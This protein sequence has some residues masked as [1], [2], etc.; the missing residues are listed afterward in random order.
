MLAG[1]V[2]VSIKH[3]P[4]SVSCC[5]LARRQDM[6]SYSSKGKAKEEK[7]LQSGAFWD[8]WVT[9]DIKYLQSSCMTRVTLIYT[10]LH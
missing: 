3:Y 6:K 4:F 7:T 9:L 2:V 10:T 5:T 1:C 8:R